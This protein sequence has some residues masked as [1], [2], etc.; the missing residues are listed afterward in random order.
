MGL[1]SRIMGKTV[2]EIA[3]P[4]EGEAV[5][6][7][8]V[9]DQT[10]AQEILGKG[11][12]IKP[13]TGRFYAPAEGELVSMFPTGHAYAIR[14]KEGT[15]VMV[16]IGFDTVKLKGEHFQVHAKEGDQVKAGDLLVE[17]DLEAVAAAGY[18][19]TT[20]VVILNTSEYASVDPSLGEKK[21]GDTILS[22]T[23]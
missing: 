15:E 20:P 9:S 7:S 6:L 2:V 16:H 3:S 4:S 13:V 1:F 17:V 11:V 18:E 8:T 10:F 23:K 5:A 21:T 22:I 12:A 19:T 14:T